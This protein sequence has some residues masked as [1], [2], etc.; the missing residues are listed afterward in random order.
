[1]SRTNRDIMA[2]FNFSFRTRNR[3]DFRRCQKLVAIVP[4]TIAVLVAGSVLM[5]SKISRLKKT[6]AN[7]YCYVDGGKR[8]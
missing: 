4:I 3:N 2:Q 7:Y 8:V 6:I 5:S 1:V